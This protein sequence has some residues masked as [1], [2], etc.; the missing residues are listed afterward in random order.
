MTHLRV[1]AIQS[2]IGPLSLAVGVE[3]LVRLDLEG[4]RDRMARDLERRFGAV[5]LTEEADPDGVVSV[6]GRYFD[7]D[8]AALDTI[9]VD[10][11]G[12][13]FQHEVWLTLRRI[14][15][16]R[17]W[18]YA[19]LAR[20]VGRPDAVRAVGAANGANPV[21]LVLPCHRVIGSD[22]RLVGYGGGLGRK[23][24]LL[25]HERASFVVDRQERLPLAPA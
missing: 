9:S 12:T 8:H 7:G 15:P 10:P 25:R 1:T 3:G 22:G 2:P 11:G 24:W 23:E 13:P 17:T 18:S 5:R 6:L 19:E 21:P 4:D 16:G 14:P 20:A